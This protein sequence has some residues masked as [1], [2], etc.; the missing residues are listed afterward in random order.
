MLKQFR[1]LPARQLVPTIAAP[2]AD[3]DVYDGAAEALLS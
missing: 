2:D 3:K 1:L